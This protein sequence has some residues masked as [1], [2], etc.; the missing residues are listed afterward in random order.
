MCAGIVN[1][2]RIIDVTGIAEAAEHFRH[3]NLR[4]PDDRVQWS[5]QLMAHIGE[6]LGLRPIRHLRLFLGVDQRGFGLLLIRD[7]DDLC[8]GARFIVAAEAQG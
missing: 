4:E 6:E 7:V 1:V 3:Q 2:A 8:N 5:A